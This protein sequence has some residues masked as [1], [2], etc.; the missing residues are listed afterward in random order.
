MRQKDFLLT[1]AASDSWQV[2]FLPGRPNG[3]PSTA[4]LRVT[5]SREGLAPYDC[6]MLVERLAVLIR[7]K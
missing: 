2:L 5:S 4:F 6:P 3:G 1:K 7:L